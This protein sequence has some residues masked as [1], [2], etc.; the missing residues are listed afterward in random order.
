[1]PSDLCSERKLLSDSV[2]R[3]LASRRTQEKRPEAADDLALVLHHA[4][5]AERVANRAL[6][7]HM[8][9]MVANVQ[10]N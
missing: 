9:D 4:R 1:M 10:R 7:D 2:V 3:Q 6:A 5:A 8:K